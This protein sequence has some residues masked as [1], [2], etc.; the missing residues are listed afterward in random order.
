VH[1]FTKKF[2]AKVHTNNL[3]AASYTCSLRKHGY[4]LRVVYAANP[5][6]KEHMDAHH[7]KVWPRRKS[8]K[9]FMVDYVT[10]NFAESFSAKVKS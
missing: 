4:H 2:K 7:G 6:V 10:G 5:A 1:N 9:I 8:N 3:W